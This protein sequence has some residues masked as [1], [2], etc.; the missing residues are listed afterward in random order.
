MRQISL[1]FVML[2]SM[3]GVTQV[4]AQVTDDFTSYPT[5]SS[6]QTLGDNWYVYPGE[7]GNYGRFGS[8]YTYKKNTY[9]GADYNYVSGYSSNYSKNVWLVLKKQVSGSVSF[10]SKMGRSSGTLYVT[11]KVTDAGDGTFTVDKSGAQ[12]FSISTTTSSNTY[13]A[14][15]SA[16]YV[17]FCLTSDQMRLL[18]VTYT[19]YVVSDGPALKVTGDTDGTL[20]FGMVNPGE[21]KVLT[22][23]NPGTADITVNITTTGGFTADGTKAIAAGGE[24]TL[25]VAAPS[26]IGASTGKITITPTVDTVE[27]VEIALSCII[28]DPEKLF[29]DFSGNALPNDWT[30]TGSWSFANGYAYGGNNT[31][32]QLTTPAMV[33]DADETFAFDAAGS[34]SWEPGYGSNYAGT[35]TVQTSTDGQSFTDLQSFSGIHYNEWQ[36]FSVAIP[37]GTKYVR[38]VSKYASIDNVYGGKLD[39]TPRPKLAVDGI[40]NGGSLSWGYSDVPAGDTKTITLKNDGTADLDVTIDATDDYTVD[41]ATATIAAGGTVEVA[42]GT[43]AHDGNGTLTITPAEGSG[44]SPYTISLSSYYK[45]PK[46]VMNLDKTSVVFGKVNEVKS[47]TIT[48]SNTGDGELVATIANDNAEN[49]TVAPAELTVAPGET[50]E[51]TIT[52]NYVEGTWGTFKANVTVTPNYGS[53]YDVKTITVSA[54]S[55]DPNVWSEDFEEGT[56]AATWNNEGKW[57]VSQPSASGNNGTYMANISSYNDPKSLTTPRLEAK[58]GDALTFYVGIQYDDE[59]LT[60]EYT[61]DDK[62]TWTAVVE[63]VTAS[64]EITFTAPADGFYY[65]RFTG[66]YAML[67]D[68]NG[69]KLAMKDHEAEITA[70]N[71]P[72]EGRQFAEYTA[73]ATVKELVGVEEEA[74]AKLMVNG[75]E[76]ATAT[77]T[78][79]AN[80]TATFTLT[81][82]PEEAVENA[83]AQ[84]VVTYAGGELATEEVAVNIA[85]AP[86]FDEMAANDAIV[87]GNEAAVLVKYTAKAGWNTIALPFALTEDILTQIFGKGWKAYE[88]NGYVD[89]ALSFK[90]ATLFAAG[91]PYV[92]YSEAP[93]ANE[94]GFV[95]NNVNVSAATANSDS[96]G[97][98]TFQATYAPIAAPDMAGKYGVVP[99]TGKIQKGSDKASLKGLRA[100]FELPADAEGSKLMMVFMDE[101]GS[102][103]SINGV[104]AIAADNAEA[105]DLNGRKLNGQKSGIIIKNGKKVVVK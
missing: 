87:T 24:E 62:A 63:P 68:F 85:A 78:V 17:A 37:E 14:G 83:T 34:S 40:E 101:D 92:V 44:L 22:L 67:D 52:Y 13:D 1:L 18:D 12:S 99:S 66:T 75:V 90:P 74:T 8:D 39:T 32:L 103:T 84:I 53:T 81:Y 41:P 77:E 91:Y 23:S 20:N 64:G 50:G 59:P 6:G 72:A 49:F 65:L 10:R 5:T 54:T 89:G 61:N 69:F 16:T 27:P 79:P 2:L 15:A 88:F 95:V 46:P 30:S 102:T 42:V 21:T 56:L 7:D 35:V 33:F 82:V 93:V 47:E 55:K 19:E 51:I 36:N 31:S 96:Y 97:G 71:I 73:T 26:T 57:T 48:V 105:F 25:A 98:A 11:N 104:E 45:E 29:E 58:A 94:N 28:K 80:G 9:D 4:K 86:V 38:F 70:N 3:M 43:P 60:I 76:V 100:Y